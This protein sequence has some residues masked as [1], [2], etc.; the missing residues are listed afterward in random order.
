MAYPGLIGVGLGRVGNPVFTGIGCFPHRKMR[1]I[2]GQQLTALV[3]VQAQFIRCGICGGR[4]CVLV[5][6]QVRLPVF[7]L[8]AG[9]LHRFETVDELDDFR[10]QDFAELT[11]A[12][13]PADGEG[14]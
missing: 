8:A 6:G 13:R 12:N 5:P 7:G 4:R 1:V 2:K 10:R 9:H 14:A 11:G 3:G